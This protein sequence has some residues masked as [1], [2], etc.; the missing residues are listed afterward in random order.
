MTLDELNGHYHD[1]CRL[2]RAEALL[3]SLRLAAYPQRAFTGMPRAKNPKDKV[4]AL[5]AEIA[6][7]ADCVMRMKEKVL[8]EEEKIA[9]FLDT[10]D[11]LVVRT[12]LRLRFLR[13]LQWAEVAEASG[14]GDDVTVRKIC[15]RYFRN[16][17]RGGL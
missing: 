8:A 9:A 16:L 2:R 13:G 6:E 12:I 14:S 17:S 4:G 11:D 7:T 3:A 10:V 15:S 5:A 1:L